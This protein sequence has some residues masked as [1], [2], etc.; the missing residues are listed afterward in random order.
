MRNAISDAGV[1]SDPLTGRLAPDPGQEDGR[2]LFLM[3]R[4]MDQV[5]R[6]SAGGN[7]VRLT[8]RRP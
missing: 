8:L 5:E 1:I 6:F 7:V 2:G 3:R 4:L